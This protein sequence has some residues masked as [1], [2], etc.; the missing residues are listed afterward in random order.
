M[1]LPD[2]D[3]R[4]T[5]LGAGIVGI[6][7]ALSLVERGVP[8][9]IVDRGDPGQE[10]SMGN[11]GIVS[12]WSVVPQSL[13]GTW[14]SIPKLLLGHG[15]PLSIRVSSLAEMIPW[16]TSFLRQGTEAKVRKT[17]K[18]MSL[19]CGPSIELYEKHLLCTGTEN[20]ISES[21][22]VH[23]FRDG[24]RA[25]MQSLEYRIRQER[26]AEIEL[27]GA[28][29]LAQLEPALSPAFKAAILIKG[30]ARV[31]S[32]GRLGAVL[33]EKARA[34]GA[35]FVKDE[36]REVVQSSA[37]WTVRC[38][39]QDL[40]AKRV[41]MSMGAW[42]PALLKSLR[43]R[44]PLM[45]ERGYHVEFNDPGCEV[46]N[47][48]MDVDTKVV[49]SSMEGGL[50]VAGQAEF[51]PVDAPPDRKRKAQL[52]DIAKSA[53]KALNTEQTR[54]W[55][56]RRPSFPD[57]LPMLGKLAEH[58]GMYFNFGH[59]HY[60]LMMAPKSGELLAQLLSGESPNQSLEA[61]SPHR[62]SR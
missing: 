32:P 3:G 29:N 22:Y 38:A 2:E 56:G 55:M 59:S 50:R 36:V 45:A 35:V 7:T 6:C 20:L 48:V 39:S 52:M 37:G 31:R 8:V 28:D 24:S 21:I 17:S 11:A 1:S 49:A 42:S 61:F 53:F 25:N 26:G 44:L 33:A 46:K 4:V 34:L 57:S 47:S 23:A 40:I 16:G 60:G 27:V 43:L 19:L 12:P 14:K 51:A 15:R 41:V 10:T 9:T 58:E 18:A 54:F 13:P 62:F 30:Q 5:I